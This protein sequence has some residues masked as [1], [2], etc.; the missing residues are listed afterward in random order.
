MFEE[1][2]HDLLSKLKSSHT[3][4]YNCDRNPTKPEHAIGATLSSVTDLETQRWMFLDVF[5]DGPA[6]RAGV[7]PGYLLMSVNGTPSTPP[8]LPTFRFGEKHELAVK[9]AKRHRNPNHRGDGS[10][11]EINAAAASVR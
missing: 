8:T 10:S 3:D 1:G 11:E 6:A 9:T 5:E 4:F 2:I 7:T